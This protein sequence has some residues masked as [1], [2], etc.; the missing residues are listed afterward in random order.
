MNS[1]KDKRSLHSTVGT[2]STRL[3]SS[4]VAGNP[5][6]R[7]GTRPP[8]T[9]SPVNLIIYIVS[10]L[11]VVAISA[12]CLGIIFFKY[13]GNGAPTPSAQMNISTIIASTSIALQKQTMAAAPLVTSTPFIVPSVTLAPSFTP[14]PS[15]TP[16]IL[17]KIKL[18]TVIPTKVAC[19][20]YCGGNLPQ[21]CGNSCIGKYNICTV[22]GGCAC[23]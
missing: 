3:S 6:R 7:T 20:V 8:A 2:S 13:Q 4:S 17:P 10:G 16:F 21:P 18:P 19:C 23:P 11:I 22:R 15:N 14:I 12:C 5:P 1:M 9:K